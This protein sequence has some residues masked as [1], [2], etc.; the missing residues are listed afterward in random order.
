M[1]SGDGQLRYRISVDFKRPVYFAD[2]Y[3]TFKEFYKRL[4]ATLNEQV[5]LRKKS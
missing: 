2:E 3:D 4:F 1:Q 5:I